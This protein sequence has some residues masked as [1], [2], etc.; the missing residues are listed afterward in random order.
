MRTVCCTIVSC[1]CHCHAL[2]GVHNTKRRHQSSE[3][4]I[5]SH[6]SCFI[7]RSPC[8]F[9]DIMSCWI[10]Y[11]CTTRVFGGLLQLSKGEAVKSFL[12]SVSSGIHAVWPNR[13]RCHAWT[14]AESLSVSSHHS[15]H[16]GTISFL[17]AITDTID[18]E[19]LSYSPRTNSL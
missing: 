9:L 12:A 16:G 14:I 5:L 6:I 1:L 17:T 2:L 3:W 7:Q 15:T 11:P 10:V 13:E 18:R 4:T 19:H 8:L